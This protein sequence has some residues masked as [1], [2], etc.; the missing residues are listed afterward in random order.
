[1]RCAGRYIFRREEI[2]CDRRWSCR[3]FALH[4]K[5]KRETPKSEWQMCDQY[6]KTYTKDDPT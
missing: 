2:E 5:P 3:N 1:M 6:E 4:E